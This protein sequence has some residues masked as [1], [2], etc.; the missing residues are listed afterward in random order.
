MTAIRTLAGLSAGASL[1]ALAPSVAAKDHSHHHPTPVPS[2]AQ[3][4]DHQDHD[5]KPSATHVG[6]DMPMTS[7]Y[8]P[9]PITR[10]A[11]GTSWQ[12][13]LGQHGGVHAVA[14][15]WTVMSHAVLNLVPAR[16]AGTR[17]SFPGC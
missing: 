17:P 2:D 15:D 16:A 1:L 5:A 10:D 13:D 6:H 12:P 14:G 9:W 8:G 7:P 11:S 4:A 3:H